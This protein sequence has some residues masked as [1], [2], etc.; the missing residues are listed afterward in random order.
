LGN[1]APLSGLSALTTL[2]VSNTNVADLAPLRGLSALTTLFVSGTPVADLTPLSRLSA[3][4]S[5]FAS[6]TQVDDLSPLSGLS[7]LA[8]LFASNT[9]VAD[10]SPLSGLS[11]LTTLSV[12]RTQVADLAPLIARITAG[13]KVKWSHAT[14]EGPGIYVEGCPLTSPLPNIVQRGTEAIL[15]YFREKSAGEVNQLYEAKMLIL[16][17]GG[18]GKTSLL[19][20]L[21]RP[22]LPLPKTDETT[23]GID[24][25]RHDWT[26]PNGRRF[27][28]NVWDFG[29]QQIYHA[30]HHFFLTRRSLY[31]LV[32]DTVKSDKNVTDPGFQYWLERVEVYGGGSPVLI[33]QNEKG[34]LSKVIDFPGIQKVYPNVLRRT[35]AT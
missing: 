3:L 7:A 8:S 21:Y 33:L 5:L 22:E 23:E 16:G 30:T 25:W 29:G 1:L 24:I 9:Q 20:R 18:A 19:R 6:N 28:L 35:A 4:A 34:G 27:R 15:N 2:D 11:A 14:W 13:C 32:D 26:M 12:S 31:L 17:D 10:L